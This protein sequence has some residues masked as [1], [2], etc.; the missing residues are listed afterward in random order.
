MSNAEYSVRW[1]R[2]SWAPT[3]QRHTRNF[4]RRTDF[5]RFVAKLLSDDRPDL[6]RVELE[7]Y[8][9]FVGPWEPLQ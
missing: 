1:R 7:T 2:V 6:S 9:R 4:A 5:D 3:T 8:W